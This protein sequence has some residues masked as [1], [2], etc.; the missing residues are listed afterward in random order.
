MPHVPTLLLRY[1]Y[2]VG[3]KCERHRSLLVLTTGSQ[4]AI[5]KGEEY[6]HL[7]STSRCFIVLPGY[8]HIPVRVNG[9]SQSFVLYCS[10]TP[11]PPVL[12]CRHSQVNSQLILLSKH[13]LLPCAWYSNVSFWCPILSTV[14][15]PVF[16][17][18]GAYPG[19][20]TA[21][22]KVKK[23]KGKKKKEVPKFKYSS[24]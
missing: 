9:I 8:M 7:Q 15:Q 5:K 24:A 10:V 19:P 20:A 6:C 2:L 23:S 14:L 22:P 18:K 12:G 11:W 17:P 21:R 13:L 4:V 3:T 16:L 1:C